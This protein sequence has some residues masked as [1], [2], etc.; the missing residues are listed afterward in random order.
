PRRTTISVDNKVF[1]KIE[2][3]EFELASG[4][5]AA[6]FDVNQ[7]QGQYPASASAQEKGPEG[8]D[9]FDELDKQIENFKKLY[10]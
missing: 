6:L 4:F 10:E 8:P 9:Q 7:I 5:P 1:A 2:V 3:K